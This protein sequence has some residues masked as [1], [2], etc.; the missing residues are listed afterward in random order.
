MNQRIELVRT[1]SRRTGTPE[2]KPSTVSPGRFNLLSASVDYVSRGHALLLGD[3]R[4]VRRA[5][6]SLANSRLVSQTLLFTEPLMGQ[7]TPMTRPCW[8]PPSILPVTPHRSGAHATPGGPSADSRPAS[9]TM[10][11]GSIWHEHRRPRAFRLRARLEAPGVGPRAA[12]AGLCRHIL[13]RRRP[14]RSSDEFGELIGEFDKPRYFQVNADQCAHSANGNTGCTRCLE[15][16]P[17]DAIAS[18]QGRIDAWIEIDP[19]RCHGVGS[20]SSACPTGAI[21]FRQ[22]ETLRLQSTLAAWLD[23]YRQ[24]GVPRR[25]F[26]SPRRVRRMAATNRPVMCWTPLEELGAAGHDL[27]L[28][29]LAAERP[30]FVQRHAAMPPRLEPL[31]R[32]RARTRPRTACRNGACTRANSGIWHRTTRQCDALPHHAVLT[33]HH[34]FSRR[35]TSA[36]VSRRFSNAWHRWRPE[37]A[38]PSLPAESLRRPRGRQCRMHVMHGLRGQLP[39]LR[40]WLPAATARTELRE[41][42]CVQCGL[43]AE[44]RPEDAIRLVPGFL[45]D[46][47][48]RERRECATRRYRSSASAAASHSPRRAPSRRSRPNSP[49]IPTSPARP[50]HDWRCEDCRVRDVWQTMTRDPES[51][52]KV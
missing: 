33:S 13:R 26:A 43:C 20:C 16:C 42:D 45:G 2:R 14:C 38:A 25:W 40:H 10:A 6:R 22:P 7:A 51:Q 21:Q 30:R 32:R 5:A 24:A 35:V 36:S 3:E 34:W 46:A 31:P 15:V 1:Q 52:L 27:W 8:R 48:R 11:S 17:A 23:A 29:A 12:T 41:A 44:A 49:T 39:H 37:S 4:A 18:R 47:A 28:T 9:S 50:A 19:Y